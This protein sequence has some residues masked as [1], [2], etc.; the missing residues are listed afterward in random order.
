MACLKNDTSYEIIMPNGLTRKQM[1]QCIGI[2]ISPTHRCE[3]QGTINNK[4][5]HSLGS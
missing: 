5:N 1:F 3:K 4:H 2:K